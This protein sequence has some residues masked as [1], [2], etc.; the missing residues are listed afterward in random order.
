MKNKILIVGIIILLIV[1]G[2]S[3]C[4]E[5]KSGDRA[6]FIGTWYVQ[7]D[8]RASLWSYTF[9]ENGS[10]MSQDFTKEPNIIYE[11]G[12]WNV[13]I[14]KKLDITTNSTFTFN[15]VFS[16]LDKTLTITPVDYLTVKM[17]LQK[18]GM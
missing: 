10:F 6:K 8:P 7:N 17:I 5:N 3:G 18:Q 2:L 1:V 11:N 14:G 15:Y 16:N 9:Y 4:A 12:T 13:K